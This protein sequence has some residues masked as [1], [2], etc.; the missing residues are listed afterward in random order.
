M[1]LVDGHW[2]EPDIMRLLLYYN[3]YTVQ[4]MEV[5]SY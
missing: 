1:L 4:Q 2:T 5:I 3:G